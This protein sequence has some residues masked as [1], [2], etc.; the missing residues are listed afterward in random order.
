MG[1]NL[2][3]LVYLYTKF[4]RRIVLIT[5]NG[6]EFKLYCG[7]I[8][9][10]P[11]ANNVSGGTAPYQYSLDGVKFSI[12]LFIQSIT[13]GLYTVIVKDATGAI[14]KYSVALHDA[15]NYPFNVGWYC[16]ACTVR[17]EW[18]NY[19]NSIKRHGPYTY[20][21]EWYDF[22]TSSQF[23]RVNTEQLY[24]NC[25]KMLMRHQLKAFYVRR[26]LFINCHNIVNSTCG[27]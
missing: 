6:L 25:K 19:S 3:C 10:Q 7:T 14:L 21:I 8:S 13:A 11:W 20:S 4:D 18:I 16:L 22:P 27:K 17:N 1:A 12:K 24:C 5:Q 23:Y 26:W 9:K 15:C 2:F